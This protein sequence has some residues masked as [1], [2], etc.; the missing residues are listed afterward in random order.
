[1]VITIEIDDSKLKDIESCYG[2]RKNST[3]KKVVF[4]ILYRYLHSEYFDENLEIEEY[5]ENNIEDFILDEIK[6]EF[7]NIFTYN[8][9]DESLLDKTLLVNAVGK[10]NFVITEYAVGRIY[11]FSEIY[12][13]LTNKANRY[14]KLVELLS[15]YY[16]SK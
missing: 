4:D 6:M 9:Y 1:M 13:K 11:A 5:D 3:I 2:N 10:G 7:I 15:S 12:F 16:L 14:G 8:G